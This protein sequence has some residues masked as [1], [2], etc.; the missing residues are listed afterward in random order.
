MTF[1]DIIEKTKKGLRRKLAVIAAA[2][3]GVLSAVI[4]A[5][6]LGIVDPFL[7]G[8]STDIQKIAKEN[9]LD[10][11]NCEIV[12]EK[13]I[14]K[15]AKIGVEM[16]K[17]GDVDAIMKGQLHSSILMKAILNKECGIAESSI[18]S[19]VGIIELPMLNR[20]LFVSDGAMC[21]YPDLMEKMHIINN[22]VTIARRL[23]IDL[24][25]VACL[26][27]VETV[28]PNM[29]ATLDASV[30]TLMN[31]RGQIKYCV[32]DGP[33]AFDNAIDIE[34]ASHKAVQ[35]A[36]NVVGNADIVIVPNIEAGNIL[37][38]ASRH[39]ANCKTV[40]LLAGAKVPVVMTSRAD[41][42]ANKLRA[43]AC[44]VYQ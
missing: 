8:D 33:L 21:M 3:E 4:E 9:N 34:A 44:A 29:Q 28:N 19:H 40:G 10:L 22:A 15:A 41:S 16:S 43:I 17:N 6:A 31:Q 39:I 38:K 13:D 42:A 5:Q 24:P 23:G 37:L 12:D 7:I 18:L 25:K 27:A 32:V 30:L 1:E 14:T 2:D 11:S 20:L 36:S 26:A 35:S